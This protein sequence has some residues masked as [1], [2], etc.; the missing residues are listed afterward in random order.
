MRGITRS[1]T[2]LALSG[3][4]ALLAPVSATAAPTPHDPDAASA[5]AE[6]VAAQLVDGQVPEDAGGGTADAVLA[7]LATGGDEQLVGQATDWLEQQAATYAGDGGPAAAKLAVVAAATGR[8]ATDFGGVDLLAGIE[9]SLTAEGQCG[10]FGYAY[11]QALCALGLQRNDADVPAG[12]IDTML[13]FQDESGAFGDDSSG[14]FAADLDGSA[15][16][17]TALAVAD[18][19]EATE[20]AV[21]VRDYLV[22]AQTDDSY[23][24]GFSPVNTTALVG[25]A[26]TLVGE[27]TSEAVDWLAGQQLD[28]GGFPAALDSQ[29]SDLL[30]T[31]QAAVFLG[32]ES[33]L[34]VGEDEAGA[35]EEPT[36]EGGTNWALWTLVGIAAVAVIGLVI[37]LASRRRDQDAAAERVGRDA[38]DGRGPAAP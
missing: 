38:A 11:G 9:E 17:L 2:A 25:S 36:D 23:W 21:A 32:G 18:H 34:S 35:L 37:A 16:A 33:M 8:D 6:Y 10:E 13:T 22:E 26:L 7:L 31:A 24:E 5:A 19:P 29:A 4:V 3:G 28:N 27:D 20:S 14:S 30:A 15:L 12:I 1:L